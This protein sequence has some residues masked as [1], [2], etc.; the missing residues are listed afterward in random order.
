MKAWL[1]AA[2]WAL[3]AAPAA[4]PAPR[5]V[6]VPTSDGW[7]LAGTLVPA[8]KKK[9]IVVLHGLASG[10]EEWQPLAEALAKRGVS[11]LALDL[12]GHGKSLKGG[13]ALGWQSFTDHGPDG[14]WAAMWKDAEAGAGWLKAQG[15]K[16]IGLGGASVGANVVL[17]AAARLPKV[18]FLVLLSPGVDYQ[19]LRAGAS[20]LA[21]GPRP[22][23]MAASAP[24]EYAFKSVDLLARARVEAGLPAD[25]LAASAGHGAQ[26]FAD[27]K[28]LAKIADWIAQQ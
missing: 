15:Y 9:A 5:Q 14:A 7:D 16:Q 3:A 11:T 27:P 10:K 25:K 8:G 19:G 24:D 23:L 22:L 2:A 12:R 1:F 20:I 21:Y 28:T 17:D 18:R 4:A 26:M 6:R 13:A